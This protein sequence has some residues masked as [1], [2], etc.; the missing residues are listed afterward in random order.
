MLQPPSPPSSSV[1]ENVIE[2]AFDLGHQIRERESL[3]FLFCFPR[4]TMI[5]LDRSVGP[6]TPRQ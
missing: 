6:P 3:I 1:S 2:F 4:Q 5:K